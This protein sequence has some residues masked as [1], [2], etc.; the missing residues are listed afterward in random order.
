MFIAYESHGFWAKTTETEN[1][2]A[3]IATGFIFDFWN[4]NF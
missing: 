3:K 4:I 1:I 2:K